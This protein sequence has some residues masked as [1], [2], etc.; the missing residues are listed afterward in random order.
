MGLRRFHDSP[1]G[2]KQGQV[3]E[4]VFVGGPGCQR[5]TARGIS[6]GVSRG[7]ADGQRCSSVR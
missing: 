2:T 1:I 4:A 3:L 6:A 7:P 5:G